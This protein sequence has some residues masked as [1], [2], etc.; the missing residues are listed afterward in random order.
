MVTLFLGPSRF[1]CGGQTRGR[2][3]RVT[4]ELGVGRG[5]NGLLRNYRYLRLVDGFSIREI[6]KG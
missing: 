4:E 6:G 1:F 2:A 3:W 5:F